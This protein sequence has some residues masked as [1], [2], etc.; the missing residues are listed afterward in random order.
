MRRPIII[1]SLVCLLL[2]GILSGVR[3][4]ET[5]SGKNENDNG[6]SQISIF[7][8]AIQLKG[9]AFFAGPT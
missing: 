7:A 2:L 3:G 8:K 4:Q 1:Q 5:D 9:H 6:Y